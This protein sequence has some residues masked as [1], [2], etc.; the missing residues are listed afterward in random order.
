M[1]KVRAY[2]YDG[3]Y[4]DK[5]KRVLLKCSVCGEDDRNKL[6]IENIM[7]GAGMGGDDF[8]FCSVCWN[9]EKLGEKILELIGYSVALKFKDECLEFEETEKE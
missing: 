2:F 7:L 3:M 1:K 6:Q 5:G 4:G 8:V 9:S